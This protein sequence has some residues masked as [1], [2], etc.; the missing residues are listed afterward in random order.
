MGKIFKS[1]YFI[2]LFLTVVFSLTVWFLPEFVGIEFL[3]ETSMR[4]TVI[5]ILS[6]ICLLYCGIKFWRNKR[7]NDEAY[8]AYANSASAEDSESEAARQEAERIQKKLDETVSLLKKSRYSLRD[9][10]HYIIIGPPG[11]GK[12]TILENSHLEE[13]PAI[14]G[15][16]PRKETT[17]LGGTRN[18]DWWITNDAILI[19]TAGRYFS[20]E[21]RSSVDKKVWKDFL[22]MLSRTRR[23]VPINGVL[24]TFDIKVLLDQSER[25]RDEHVRKIQK[26]LHEL[27]EILGIRFPIYVLFTKLDLVAGFSQYFTGFERRQELLDQVFGFTFPLAETEEKTGFAKFKSYFSGSMEEFKSNTDDF[28][29]EFELLIKRLSDGVLASVSSTNNMYNR[30]LIYR[31]PQELSLAKPVLEDFIGKIFEPLRGYDPVLRGV[32]FT[33]GTQ[34]GS[35]I[36]RVMAGYVKNLNLDIASVSE[37][38]QGEGRSYFINKLLKNV[39]FEEQNL[40]SFGS[41]HFSKLRFN[42]LFAGCLV[43]MIVLLGYGFYFWPNSASANKDKLDTIETLVKEYRENEFDPEKTTSKSNLKGVLPAL[44]KAYEASKVFNVEQDPGSMHHGL[45]QGEEFA[46]QRFYP[47]ALDKVFLRHIALY[48]LETMKNAVENSKPQK[49]SLY[50]QISMA[51]EAYLMIQEEYGKEHFDKETFDTI[52]KGY[53]GQDANI[54]QTTYDN[55]SQHLARLNPE[56]FIK[57]DEI[58]DKELIEKLQYKL[59]KESNA[60]DRVYDEIVQ[61]AREYELEDH[62]LDSKAKELFSPVS[63]QDY[64]SVAGLYTAA[65]YCNFFKSAVNGSSIEQ[66]IRHMNWLLGNDEKAYQNQDKIK[67]IYARR[68]IKAWKTFLDNV[69]IKSMSDMDGLGTRLYELS[70]SD[71]QLKKFLTDIKNNTD[72]ELSCADEEE[73]NSTENTAMK[74]AEEEIARRSTSLSKTKRIKDK[75]AKT[76][77]NKPQKTPKEVQAIRD[78]FKNMNELDIAQFDDELRKVQELVERDPANAEHAIKNLN[79]KV[80]NMLGNADSEDPMNNLKRMFDTLTGAAQESA[81]KG[82]AESIATKLNNAWDGIVDRCRNVQG[83]YPPRQEVPT[84]AFASFF[85]SNG[86]LDNFE[87]N[88]FKPA[89]SE[90]PSLQ[91]PEIFKGGKYLREAFFDGGRLGVSFSLEPVETSGI[92]SATFRYGNKTLVY[93]AGTPTRSETFTWPNSDGDKPSVSLKFESGDSPQISG[94]NGNWEI[95]NFIRKAKRGNLVIFSDRGGSVTYRLKVNNRDNPFNRQVNISCPAKIV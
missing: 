18:C 32:Y 65:G 5:A 16:G 84:N 47:N 15:Q 9:T 20:E 48:L 37:T 13:P 43:S 67:A 79:R 24:I 27:N 61:N 10:P 40:V 46:A 39:I 28:S 68:Y 34:T 30:E 78:A 55:L 36:E 25:D 45:Y 74:V 53:W 88:D 22:Q 90:L 21:S 19:D 95:F 81:A 26:H 29:R 73:E 42:A 72:V 4:W 14:R 71:S 59:E 87:R 75:F 49:E 56:D 92:V 3:Y 8:D 50:T 44:D 63:G 77:K 85:T 69:R 60:T 94:S 33:S 93:E 76:G 17:G 89:K 12:T 23:E 64:P 52:L 91:E 35:P 31:F 57:A 1:G 58:D 41:G 82:K 70:G 51:L 80:E 86:D 83:A 62:S 2:S 54:S 11:S 66:A 38:F 7:R 6:G